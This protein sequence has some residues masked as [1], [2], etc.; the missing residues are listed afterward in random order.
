MRLYIYW[1]NVI[2]K[3]VLNKLDRKAGTRQPVY[4]A[5]INIYLFKSRLRGGVAFLRNYAYN[6]TFRFFL[7]FLVF[8]NF[9]VL[10]NFKFTIFFLQKL[11]G[12]QD[13]FFQK[14]EKKLFF[15]RGVNYYRQR[16]KLLT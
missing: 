12:I 3:L 13:F 14:Y 6:T 10:F 15:V 16:T 1:L 9:T 11:D 5:K 4:A 8:F 2:Y 7:W